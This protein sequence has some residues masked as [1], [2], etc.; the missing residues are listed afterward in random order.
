MR[1]WLSC[2]LLL[3]MVGSQLF[4]FD[5]AAATSAPQISTELQKAQDLLAK[6]SPEERVG[7]LFLVTYQG[8]DTGEGST[9]ASL[10]RDQ[11]IGGVVLRAD[12]DNF[13]T[14]ENLPAA[15]KGS[16]NALQTINWKTT[17]AGLQIGSEGVQ[18]GGNYVPLFVGISQEGDLSPNDQIIN[19]LTPLPSAM[20]IGATW[21]P[22]NA[23][24]VGK[25]L[26]SELEALGFNLLL[27]PSLD[28]LDLV[29]TD[30]GDD[31]GT[32][33]FGGDPYWVGQFGK[34]YISGVHE[35]SNNKILVVS[36]H[37][38]GRGG[39]DRQPEDEVATVRKSLEQLKQIELYPF[40]AVT[41][42]S[43]NLSEQT[44]GLLLSHI[45]YQG[46][47]G[48]IRATTRPVSFDETALHAI[49]A[50][51]QFAGWREQGGIIVSDD[52]GSAAVKKFFAPTGTNFDARQVAKATLLAGNDLL[53]LGNIQSTNDE[54]AYQTAVKIHEYFV[55]KYKEDPVF[56]QRVDEA[57]LRILTLKYQLYSYFSLGMVTVS[58]N[59]LEQVGISQQVTLDIARQAVTLV[60]PTLQDLNTDLPNPPSAEDQII[61]ISNEIPQTQCSSC[62]DQSIFLAKELM[63]AVMR[64]YGP[65]AGDIVQANRLSAYS[66]ADLKSYLDG[67]DAEKDMGSKLEQADWIVIAFSEF[68][69]NSEESLAFQRLFSE[70]P[71]LV[72]NKKI[73]GMAFNAPY[74]PDATDISKFTA[75]YALYSKTPQFIEIA[76]RT[77]FKE[78][79][80]GGILPVSVSSIGYDL[81]TATTPNPNQII[82]LMVVRENEEP[83]EAESSTSTSEQPMVINAG[84]TL[85][86]Q[87]G[88]IKDQNG[89]PVPDGTVVRFVV[90]TQSSSGTV[91]QIEAQTISGVARTAYRIPEKGTVELT[92]TAEP[93]TVSQILKL[94]INPGGGTLTSIDPTFVPTAKGEANVP[95]PPATTEAT[96]SAERHLQGLPSAADWFVATFLIGISIA[97]LYQYGESRRKTLWNPWIPFVCGA[98]G[99]GAYL[100]P[101][102]GAGFSQ[103]LVREFGTIAT[104]GLSLS[105]CAIG[106]I[107]AIFVRK[108]SKS[109]KYP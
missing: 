37:F 71:G 40:F 102:L 19:G 31:L 78:I 67:T 46:F 100:L 109:R 34:A 25:I 104:V 79:T 59:N 77:L 108:L 82:P 61:F 69:L 47:Q 39:S 52:L 62:A 88:I 6:M 2:A 5:V 97:V 90:D 98:L 49:L 33:T 107:L 12:N 96:T 70:K 36:K 29:K 9:I 106:A 54:S 87:T 86:L 17:I 26:G 42:Q 72:R 14:T 3:I 65:L 56:Q 60:S 10:I 18:P 83:G 51:E 75:Y 43:E 1:R 11:H 53:Y 105:G 7:Q 66:F 44:D 30:I 41:Q 16:I 35:G 84:D 8:S 81:I 32:R 50:L 15:V 22:D 27:G 23:K 4:T 38:P 68:K 74:Y 76:A 55:Q 85:V 101:A 93:A 58:A 57:V 13:A 103:N 80:P 92:V 45:R 91:E 28:V 64:L 94:E 99:Y 21:K 24:A 89:N 63:N 73:I 20:A 48:N 95:T